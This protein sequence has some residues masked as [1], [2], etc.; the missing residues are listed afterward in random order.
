VTGKGRRLA[1]AAIAMG[2]AVVAVTVFLLRGRILEEWHIYRFAHGDESAKKAE[3]EWIGEHGGGNSLLALSEWSAANSVLIFLESNLLREKGEIPMQ[4]E[5][6]RRFE[7]DY[8]QREFE[9]KPIIFL[10]NQAGKKF[11]DRLGPERLTEIRMK[12]LASLKISRRFLVVIARGAIIDVSNT[13]F[14]PGAIDLAARRL[15]ECLSD[16]DPLVRTGAIYGLGDAGERAGPGIFEAP[17]PLR[18]DP[19]EV[20]REAAVYVIRRL[21]TIP[22]FRPEAPH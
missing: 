2:L 1:I 11:R 6:N 9:N 12:Y 8:M 4:P 20:V 15:R 10:V 17:T 14:T 3:L 13:R 7:K 22:S 5:A 21:S 16:P 19:D 18:E